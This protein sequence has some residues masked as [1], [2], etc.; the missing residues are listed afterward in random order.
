MKRP[1]ILFVICLYLLTSILTS[2]PVQAL[3]IATS[4]AEI[5]NVT[6]APDAGTFSWTGP[7]WVQAGALADDYKSIFATGFDPD[8]DGDGVAD[9]YA[10]TTLAESEGHANGNTLTVS[11]ASEARADSPSAWSTAVSYGELFNTFVITG[12]TSGN[13]VDL[14]VAYD[15]SALLGITADPYGP[16]FDSKYV[17]RLAISD[18]FTDWILEDENQIMGGPG[19]NVSQGYGGT[20]SDTFTLQYEVP[21][22]FIISADADSEI[23]PIP[24]PTTMLLFGIGLLGMSIFRRH[25]TKKQ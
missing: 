4:E 10:S 15:Y 9:A 13:P 14:S 5:T 6:F 25:G 1:A 8:W 17:V 3:S 11:F 12:G 18:G 22:T 24:E 2:T 20:L 19:G 21:Y 7:W 23:T 16:I